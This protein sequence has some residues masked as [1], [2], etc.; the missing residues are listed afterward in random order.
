MIKRTRETIIYV[1]IVIVLP[2][3][4]KNT[5]IKVANIINVLKFMIFCEAHQSIQW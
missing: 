5:I 1:L 3:I 2:F 4:I